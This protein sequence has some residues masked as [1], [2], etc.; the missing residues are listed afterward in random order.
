MRRPAGFRP[1]YCRAPRYSRVLGLTTACDPDVAR[2]AA[3][4]SLANDFATLENAICVHDLLDLPL[5]EEL[6][7]LYG[8]MHP[9]NPRA[10]QAPG[11][12][13]RG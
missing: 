3:A 8:A 5:P 4:T 1:R 10:R 12:G 11:D 2:A 13:R 9:R 7:A 6:L